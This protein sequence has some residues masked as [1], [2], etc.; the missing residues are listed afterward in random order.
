M[1]DPVWVICTKGVWTKVATSVTSGNIH[2]DTAI[3]SQYLQMYKMTGNPA[4]TLVGEG[5]RA[6]EDSLSESINAT[7]AI[8]VYIWVVGDVDG[9]VRVDV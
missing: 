8:D 5:V 1:A 4:P 9:L 7:A 2:K 3:Q 6:F